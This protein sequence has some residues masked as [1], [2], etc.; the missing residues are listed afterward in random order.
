MPSNRRG[1]GRGL[2]ALIPAQ[3]ADSGEFDAV[4]KVSHQA[5]VVQELA[6]AEIKPNPHQPRQ[7][8]DEAA[9][10]E[11]AA[12]IKQFGIVQPLVVTKTSGGYELIA[13]ERRLR[14]AKLAG[15]PHVPAVIRSFDEQA[16]LEVALI[17]NIQ[18]SQLNAIETATA[19]RQLMDQF[20]LKLEDMS[21]RVGKDVST[22]SNTMRLLGLPTEA[23]RALVAGQITE[24]HARAILS[25]PNKDKQLALLSEI[26]GRSL[27]VRQAEAVARSLK[28][29]RAKRAQALTNL[30]TTNPWTERLSEALN[31]SV[32]ISRSA[33]GNRLVINYRNDQELEQIVKRLSA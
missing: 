29:P 25:Q 14:A 3:L 11:L 6:P 10:K 12:S 33:K 15:L 18:R 8:F 9:L 1:L 5:N 23:K 17:E 28:V 27:T 16:K 32:S 13:G 19:Y 4:A 22:I 26:T 21:R 7:S 31:T 20:N 24:G 2:D 30:D